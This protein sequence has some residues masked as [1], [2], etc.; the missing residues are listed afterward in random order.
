MGQLAP[1]VNVYHA[2]RNFWIDHLTTK[3]M[4]FTT[5]CYGQSAVTSTVYKMIYFSLE[6][7]RVCTW[8]LLVGSLNH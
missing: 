4:D 7:T 2:H 6:E 1:L 8:K 3:P 5:V